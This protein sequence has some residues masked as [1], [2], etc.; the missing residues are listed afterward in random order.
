MAWDSVHPS[1]SALDRMQSRRLYP[2]DR[3]IYASGVMPENK[4]VNAGLSKLKSDAGHIVLRIPPGGAAF[5]TF[6]LKKQR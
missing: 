6:I 1:I 5:Q 3:A 4:N 2:G